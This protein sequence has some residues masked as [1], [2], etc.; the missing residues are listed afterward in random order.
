[1]LGFAGQLA[2]DGEYAVYGVQAFACTLALEGAWQTIGGAGEL[3]LA[4]SF[5]D[6]P[7][8]GAGELALAG[9]WSYAGISTGCCAEP[10]PSYLDFTFGD[11]GACPVLDNL[12]VTLVYNSSTGQWESGPILPLEPPDPPYFLYFFCDASNHLNFLFY[13]NSGFVDGETAFAGW[14]CSPF[15][16]QFDLSTGAGRP[17]AATVIPACVVASF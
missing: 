5:D 2:L 14:S 7:S 8:Y 9:S 1:M 6:S 10:I 4:G 13:N 16:W 17:C 12:Q 11:S 3:A 15:R